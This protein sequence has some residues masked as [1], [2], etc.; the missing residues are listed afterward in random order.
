M[1]WRRTGVQHVDVLSAMSDTPERQKSID[2]V[3][4][5][6]AGTSILV[7]KGNPQKINSLD[8]F[9]GKTIALQRGTTQDDVAK[10]HEL[11]ES[12]RTVGKIVLKIR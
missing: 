4:Y 12:N 6:T 9:C 7:K 8:D 3:D 11:L 2:F 1:A 10:A 5:F